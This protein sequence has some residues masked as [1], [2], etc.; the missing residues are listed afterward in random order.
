[1]F[2][3]SYCCWLCT[4]EACRLFSCPDTTSEKEP[5]VSDRPASGLMDGELTCP[6]I[7]EPHPIC[8]ALGRHDMA[9]VF[10]PQRK[11]GVISY[12]GN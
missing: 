9:A 7:L 12:R 6:K 10:A 8:V 4:M 3:V 2:L 5:G 1:M 11:G